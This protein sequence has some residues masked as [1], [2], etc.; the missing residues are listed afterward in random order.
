MTLRAFLFIV[1]SALFHVLWNSCLKKCKDKPTAVFLMMTVTVC[2]FA[3]GIISF[4]PVK[5]LFVPSAI[6]TALGAGFFFFL[7][8]YFVAL[9]YEKGD[10]TLVYPL[11]V[12]GPVYIVIWSYFL[13]GEHITL[14]GAVGIVLIIYGAVTIQS[15]NFMIFSNMA[16]IFEE[17]K[18]SLTESGIIFALAAAFFYSFGAVADKMGVM[19]GNITIYTFHLSIYMT[20]FHLLRIISQCHISHIVTEIKLNPIAIIL[21]GIVMLFSFI[22]FRIGLQ[23]ALASYASALRQVSTLF[24]ILIGFFIFRERINI[25]RVIS[26][27]I[28]VAGAVLIKLG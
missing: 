23:D 13:I 26:S 6:V 28:I 24:G 25:R 17:K 21:G 3:T 11:T 22:T 8:Q 5:E 12:T 14:T 9:A 10:L 15:G 2:C 20:L 27:L 19:S 4:Y 7:Y 18:S 16:T 1:A